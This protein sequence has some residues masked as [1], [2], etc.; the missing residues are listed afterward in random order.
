MGDS[1]AALLQK[2]ARAREALAGSQQQLAHAERRLLGQLG[3]LL[4]SAGY[5]IVPLGGRP[6]AGKAPTIRKRARQK[7]L[8]CPHCDRR[9]S[10][11]LHLARHTSAMHGKPKGARDITKVATKKSTH[12]PGP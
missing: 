1:A 12:P 9:F 4:S 5:R 11:R 8:R 10:H 2:L 7:R 6:A 3:P